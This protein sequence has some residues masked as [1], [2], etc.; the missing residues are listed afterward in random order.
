MEDFYQ[1]YDMIWSPSIWVPP[2]YTWEDVRVEKCKDLWS[3][4]FIIAGTFLLFKY[5]I[6]SPFVFYPL[7]KCLKIRSKPYK[8]PP[9]NNKLESIHKKYRSRAP[10]EL[11]RDVAKDLGWSERQVQRWLRQRTA[12]TQSTTLQK[13][14][15]CAWQLVYYSLYCIFGVIVHYDK[16]WFYDVTYCFRNFPH[17]D[18][19]YDIWWYYMIPLGF[20]WAQTVTHFLQPK[21]HDSLQML[22][23]H[24][25]TIMLMTISWITNLIRMGTLVLLLH[26]CADIP[27]LL[28]KI[29]GYC[30]NDKL[31]DVFFVVFLLLWIVTRLGFYP[32]HVLYTTLFV[33]HVQENIFYP[34]YYI[35]NSLLLAILVM[36]ILWTYSIIQ[37][38]IRKFSTNKIQDVRSSG[39]EMSDADEA[40]PPIKPSKKVN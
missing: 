12:C 34:V 7:G 8:K 11:I 35:L 3:Y 22:V 30:G 23:H 17:H 38:I 15:D 31:M 5:L 13:F 1:L 25:V 24:L 26:E 9:S 10:F 36:H 29:S 32:F 18:M 40:Y 27:L 2:G 37:V 33:A 4:P 14:D 16:P 21:R 19:D 6:L 39:S 28:A 20:Y